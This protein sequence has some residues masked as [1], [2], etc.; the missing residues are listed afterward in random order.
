MQM[1][2]SRVVLVY[3]SAE[4]GYNRDVSDSGRKVVCDCDEIPDCVE[5]D[6]PP[7]LKASIIGRGAH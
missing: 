4:K 7:A 1:T 6:G 2:H 3:L 5:M